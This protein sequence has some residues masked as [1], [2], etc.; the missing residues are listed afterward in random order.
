VNDQ[1]RITLH[2]H[3]TAEKRCLTIWVVRRPTRPNR[4]YLGRAARVE[5]PDGGFELDID[6]DPVML[7]ELLGAE[8]R[9]AKEL[10]WQRLM[11]LSVAGYRSP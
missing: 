10:L 2:G 8:F 4:A 7:Q 1:Y 3:C 9:E 6:I 11:Q 5:Y